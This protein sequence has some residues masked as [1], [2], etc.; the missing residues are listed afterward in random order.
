ML[1]K[2]SSLYQSE[3]LPLPDEGNGQ[4]ALGCLPSIPHSIVCG[5]VFFHPVNALKVIVTLF[6]I[7]YLTFQ[8]IFLFLCHVLLFILNCFSASSPLYL[9][10][11]ISTYQLYFQAL[12]E[13]IRTEGN[14]KN[15]PVFL[16]EILVLRV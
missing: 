9:L 14:G 5:T 16:K 1:L 13:M 10:K 3:E 11:K 12:C 4:R 2:T 15:V 6:R 8:S 7:F